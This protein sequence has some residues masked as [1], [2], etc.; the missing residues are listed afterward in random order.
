MRVSSRPHLTIS[1]CMAPNMDGF[2]CEL[3]GYLAEKLSTPVDLKIDIPWQERE[4]MFDAGK[5]QLCWICGLPY[6]WKA[7]EHPGRFAPLVAPVMAGSRYQ[8]RPIYY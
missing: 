6:I 5:I 7:D 2:C 1:T 3:A 4:R 8:D